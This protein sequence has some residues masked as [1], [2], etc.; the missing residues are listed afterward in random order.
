MKKHNKTIEAQEFSLIFNTIHGH[1]HIEKGQTY[2]TM[3]AT[4]ADYLDKYEIF[5]IE[6]V[7]VQEHKLREIELCY[8]LP[9]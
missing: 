7:A 5:T 9:F 1:Q 4:I 8:N 2:L 6:M 3:S